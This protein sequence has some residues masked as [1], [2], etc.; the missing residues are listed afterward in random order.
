LVIHTRRLG[1]LYSGD[2]T[3]TLRQTGHYFWLIGII[4]S[5]DYTKTLRQTGHYFWL[6]GIF[7]RLH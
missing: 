1:I 6:I 5:G 7:W 3:K 2:Y 4:Y